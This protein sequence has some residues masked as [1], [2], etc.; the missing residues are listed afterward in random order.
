MAASDYLTFYAR[1]FGTVEVD[2]TWYRP[3][4]ARMV[5][6]WRASTPDGFRFSL[7]A[8]RTIT[9]DARL[10][11]CEDELAEFLAVTERLG[12]KLGPVLFQFPYFKKADFPHASAFL[13]R[14]APFLEMLPPE[15]EFAVEVRNKSWVAAPLLD[16]LR[17]RGVALALI[18]H[19]WMLTAGGYGRVPGI[20]TADFLYVRL[21]GDRYGI[22]ERTKEWDRLIVDRTK[23]TAAW[24]ALLGELWDRVARTYTY[25][26][27]HYA[28]CAYESARLL[29]QAWGE[30]ASGS[31]RARG[32]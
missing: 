31:N 7:K 13:D 19:P 8:P 30:R 32:T 24:T 27:N 4:T 14:L 6:A 26:N 1:E 5:D 25:F 23:E 10:V 20:V 18:D 3:P 11:G 15:R 16:L 12:E 22:E 21:L 28:G 17:S 2:S 9:H 29:R